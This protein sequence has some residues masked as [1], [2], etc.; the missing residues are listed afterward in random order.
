MLI[1]SWLKRRPVLLVPLYKPNTWT[2]IYPRMPHKDYG[3]ECPMHAYTGCKPPEVGR[4]DLS[5]FKK[6]HSWLAP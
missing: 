1:Y 5:S 3:K 2:D 6:V 4:T